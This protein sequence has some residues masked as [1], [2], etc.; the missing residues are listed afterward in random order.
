MS[1]EVVQEKEAPKVTVKA[2]AAYAILP[3]IIPRLNRLAQG[4]QQVFFSFVRILG[5]VGLI[6]KNHPCLRE[7]NIGRYPISHILIYAWQ[8]LKFN[9]ENIP[10]IAMFFAVCLT[11]LLMCATFFVFILQFL[12]HVNVTQAQYFYFEPPVPADTGMDY[13]RNEDW[14]FIYLERIFGNAGGGTMDFWIENGSNIN[15]TVANPWFTA[16]FEGMIKAYSNAI[17]ALAAFMIIYIIVMALVEAAKTGK[18]FGEKFDPIWAPIRMAIALFL[19]VPVTNYNAAQ[20]LVFKSSEWG[21]NLANNVWLR[22]LHAMVETDNNVQDPSKKKDNV[23]FVGTT[24]VDKGYRFVRDVFLIHVCM[25]GYNLIECS[26]NAS[27]TPMTTTIGKDDVHIIYNF[28]IPQ[29]IAYCGSVR[30]AGPVQVPEGAPGN[31]KTG[32]LDTTKFWPNKVVMGYSTAVGNMVSPEYSMSTVADKFA[33]AFDDDKEADFSKIAGA[34]E[35]KQWINDYRSVAYGLDANGRVF[36]NYLPENRTYNEWILKS[37]EKD[38]EYGW[39]TAGVFYLRIT[40]AMAMASKAIQSAPAVTSYPVNYTRIF[41]TPEM[42]SISN[43]RG[44]EL[45]EMQDKARNLACK[46]KSTPQR[47]YAL[48]GKADDWFRSAPIGVSKLYAELGGAAFEDEM[49]VA[50]KEDAQEARDDSIFNTIAVGLF[51]MAKI[52]LADLHPLGTVIEWG[53]IFMQTAF[54]AYII[55]VAAGLLTTAVKALTFGLIN[56]GSPLSSLAVT[57]GHMFLIPGFILTFVVPLIPAFYF[58]FAVLEWIISIVEAVIAMPLWAL[59]FLTSEGDLLGD[60]VKGVKSLF[61]IILR[62]MIIVASL[63]F[64]VTIF[65]AGVMFIND[66]YALFLGAYDSA[67]ESVLGPVSSLTMALG[68]ALIY[69]FLVY[70]YATSCFKLVDKLPDLFGRWLRL[71]PGFNTM[72]RAGHM[73]LRQQLIEGYIFKEMLERGT[74]FAQSIGAGV[75]QSVSSI[76]KLFKGSK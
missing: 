38:A 69:M 17:F 27:T 73:D 74:G 57:V 47:L 65:T 10:Q 22:A 18:P 55:A 1:S 40:N 44:S 33:A 41:A 39:G 64:S 66:G 67:T 54:A 9:R 60:A 19:L 72:I 53:H 61:E 35:V 52:N 43:Q 50:Q 75:S 26:A 14:I 49:K 56:L 42:P 20:F 62:P 29:A 5:V 71:P 76:A 8:N 45:C 6:D 16:M 25:K 58:L 48:L 11:L 28:G 68:A 2:V 32:P 3:G 12:F 13:S 31:D 59:S 23:T 46:S 4:V 21:T 34:A 70:T 30:F 51:E 15:A 37:L 36:G 63:V 7:E 24:K